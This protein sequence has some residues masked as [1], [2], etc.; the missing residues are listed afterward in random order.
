MSSCGNEDETCTAEQLE[1]KTVEK[2]ST[3]EA[4]SPEV[5]G[6]IL[7]FLPAKTLLHLSE[8]SRKLHSECIGNSGIW[9]GLLK[10]KSSVFYLIVCFSG[11]LQRTACYV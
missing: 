11:K 4:L 5:L 3:L 2:R 6:L 7:E 1:S 10:V 8:T 9:K